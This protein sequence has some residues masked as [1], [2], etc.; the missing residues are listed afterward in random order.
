MKLPPALRSL[1]HRNFRLFFA[2]QGV[3][4]IGT[5]M[6]QVAPARQAFMVEMVTDHDSLTNAI[7]LNSSIVNAARLVGPAMAGLLLARTSAGVCF[8]VNG[9]SY[10]AVLIALA[11]MRVPPAASPGR[12]RVP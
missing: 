6:Q 2:G 10:V 5:W 12:P 8:L 9:V 3:S 7:A 11:A 4:L 1:A